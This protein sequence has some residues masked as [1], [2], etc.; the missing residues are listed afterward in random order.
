MSAE[1]D[2]CTTGQLRLVG[3]GNYFE[4]R[5]E[6]C[7]SGIWGTVCDDSWDAREAEVVCR[8]LGFNATGAQELRR[9]SPFGEGIG[10]IFLD[11]VRC[12]G[13]E[14]TLMS[15]PNVDPEEENDCAHSEDAGVRCLAGEN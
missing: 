14:Q 6:F 7:F 8:Q 2:A 3:G 9:A 11:E 4:G 12:K 15:C 5:L 1:M 13:S 10:P